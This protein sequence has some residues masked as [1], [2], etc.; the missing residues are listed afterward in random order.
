MENSG[1][2]TRPAIHAILTN[3]IFRAVTSIVWP[4]TWMVVDETGRRYHDGI[5]LFAAAR[6]ARTMERQSSD[7][8]A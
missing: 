1:R 7:S 4:H 3:V 2:L 8:H 6:K 5:D